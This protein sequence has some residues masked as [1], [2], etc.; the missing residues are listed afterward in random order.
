MLAVSDCCE[1]RLGLF[2]EQRDE[3]VTRADACISSAAVVSFSAWDVLVTGR[4]AAV[5]VHAPH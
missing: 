1:H 2:N 3:V 5:V 4:K